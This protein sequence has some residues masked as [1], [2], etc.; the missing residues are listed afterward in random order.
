MFMEMVAAARSSYLSHFRSS[1]ERLSGKDGFVVEL[2]MKPNGRTTPEPYCLMRVDVIYGTPSAP[3][4]VRIAADRLSPGSAPSFLRNG[5]EV[6]VDGFSWE[7]CMLEF[8]SEKFSIEL[9]R[10]WL[11]RWLDPNETRKPDSA[12]LCGV[13]HDLAWDCEQ[14]AWSL[15]I[16]LGTAPTTALAELL[17]VVRASGAESCRFFCPVA[18]SDDE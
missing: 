3:K 1:V 18:G 5:L 6:Q 17:D 9:L 8:A 10:P 7:S 13:V 2:L 14:A 16:D 11:I 4:I 15:R 12:G